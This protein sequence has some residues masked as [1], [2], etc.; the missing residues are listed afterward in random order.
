MRIVRTITE[1]RSA[2]AVQRNELADQRSEAAPGRVGL[3]PTMGAL[4]EGHLSLVEAARAGSD[5]V[6][7]SIFVNPKQFEDSSDLAAY[8]RDEGRDAAL[9]ERAGVDL[10][11]APDANELYPNGFATTV[12]VAG[13]ITSTL[14]GAERGSAHFDGV[15]TVVSKLLIASGADTAYFGQKDAQQLVVVQ[16]MVTDLG[17]PTRIVPCPTSRDA[18]GLARSSRNARLSPEQRA[19]ALAVPRALEA[20]RDLAAS[21][22]VDAAALRDAGLRVLA[23]ASVTAE[24]LAIVDPATLE[25]MPQLTGNALCAVAA[26]VGGV[27]IIDNVLLGG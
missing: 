19:S 1:L 26:R 11:F 17:L 27:R 22:E 3:V 5:I 12:H 13:V 20:V 4:H 15:A 2:I 14:E 10:L 6:V 8:P 21:G 7:M 24:Y 16:R 25:E 9:A 23:E 18:D